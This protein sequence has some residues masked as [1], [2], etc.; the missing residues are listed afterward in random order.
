MRLGLFAGPIYTIPFLGC[1][2][3]LF[4]RWWMS[5]DDV[6]QDAFV[7]LTEKATIEVDEN[8]CT[9]QSC[10]FILS[11]TLILRGRIFFESSDAD[12]V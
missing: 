3:S 9:D 5:R 11:G 2:F 1:L 8:T 7:E 10:Q 6:D 12:L 4:F